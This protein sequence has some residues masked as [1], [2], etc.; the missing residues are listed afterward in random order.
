MKKSFLIALTSLLLA[1]CV[2]GNTEYPNLTACMKKNQ[3]VMFG[4]SWCP[5]C[6]AQKKLFGKSVKDMPYFECAVGG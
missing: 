4:A 6:A 1:S 2:A 5:H 3:T